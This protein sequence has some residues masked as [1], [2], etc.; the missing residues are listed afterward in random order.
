MKKIETI[1]HHLLNIA[2]TKKEFKHTQKDLALKFGYSLSTVNHALAIPAQIGAVRKSSKFF[3]L[4]DFWKL[5]YF[6]ASLRNLEK[7]IIYQTRIEATINELE[8]LIPS[9]AIYAGYSAANRM[10]KEPPAD[11]SKVYF[12][13]DKEKLNEVLK[14]FPP[15]QKPKA[16]NK[17]PPAYA[18]RYFELLASRGR[19]TYSPRFTQKDLRSQYNLFVL[20]KNPQIPCPKGFTTLP[21]TFVDIWNF[22]DWYSKDFILALEERIHGILS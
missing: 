5:L 6:W 16:E 22:K 13:A 3:L 10:L 12:Y 21:L 11:Y 14:R 4:S 18:G 2:L 19:T 20:T 1:W 8:G 15:V 7:D 9:Q 17:L